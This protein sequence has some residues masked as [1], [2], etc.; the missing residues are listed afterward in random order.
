VATD[1]KNAK[2]AQPLRV[3]YD[4]KKATPA[5]RAAIAA[6]LK[7]AARAQVTL[8]EAGGSILAPFIRTPARGTSRLAET[9]S[10][11]VRTPAGILL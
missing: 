8:S 4:P 6:R 10:L 5:E 7:Q 3:S 2:V 1:P 11:G 9:A